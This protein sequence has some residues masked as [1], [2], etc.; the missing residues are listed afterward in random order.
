MH[1]VGFITAVTVSTEVQDFG[2]FRP[3]QLMGYTGLCPSEHSSGGRR[4][5]GALSRT[6]NAH[7]RRVLV[8]AAWHYRKPWRASRRRRSQEAALPVWLRQ[9]AQRAESR[10]HRR[11]TRIVSRG[12]PP[13]KAAVAVARELVTFMWAIDR[14]LA[15]QRQA[16]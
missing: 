3:R 5:Q 11:F 10:L 6:G 2:R 8:E 15:G 14:T 13:Q 7:L 9:L 1:G 16:A 12:K 4:R